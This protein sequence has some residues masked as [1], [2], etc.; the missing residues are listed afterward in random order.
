MFIHA[1]CATSG[2]GTPLAPGPFYVRISG[3]TQ[4]PPR[5]PSTARAVAFFVEVRCVER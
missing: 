1:W 2:L 4:K 3:H 5:F